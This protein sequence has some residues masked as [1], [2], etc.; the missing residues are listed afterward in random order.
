M[1]TVH[2]NSF[3]CECKKMH[4]LNFTVNGL[5]VDNVSRLKDAVLLT[6]RVIKKNNQTNFVNNYVHHDFFY[7]VHFYRNN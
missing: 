6:I 3:N 5:T 7:E 1:Y 2:I 4:F